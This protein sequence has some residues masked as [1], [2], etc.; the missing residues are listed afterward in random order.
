MMHDQMWSGCSSRP[1]VG[2]EQRRYFWFFPGRSKVKLAP[3]ATSWLM[4]GS[5]SRRSLH[6]CQHP[7][8]HPPIDSSQPFSARSRAGLRLAV[9][10]KTCLGQLSYLPLVLR[11]SLSPAWRLSLA[12]GASGVL[13]APARDTAKGG[14][15]KFSNGLPRVPSNSRMYVSRLQCDDAPDRKCPLPDPFRPV[16]IPRVPHPSRLTERHPKK[17]EK[18]SG[19]T[20]NATQ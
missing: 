13:L 10:C 1:L 20:A 12:T 7:H 17:T 2:T 3:G 15:D 16:A 14:E 11:V 19:H 18:S 9:V 6:V 4:G 8:H 5:P